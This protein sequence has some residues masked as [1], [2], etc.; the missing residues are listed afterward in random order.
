MDT[1]LNITHCDLA[2]RPD[3]S[4]AAHLVG[5]GRPSCPYYKK[6]AK[7]GGHR[8]EWLVQ[9]YHELMHKGIPNVKCCTGNDHVRVLLRVIRLA[10]GADT[11]KLCPDSSL[12][13]DPSPFCLA[14]RLANFKGVHIGGNCHTWSFVQNPDACR[15]PEGIARLYNLQ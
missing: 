12:M 11:R 15:Q 1:V 5:N 13:S 6:Q 8:Q 2:K 3:Y 9:R 7:N 10:Y 4:L 14:Y